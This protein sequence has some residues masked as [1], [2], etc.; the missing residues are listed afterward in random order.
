MSSTHTMNSATAVGTLTGTVLTVADNLQKISD[1]NFISWYD[2]EKT[3]LL[4]IVG[5]FAGFVTSLLLK[6]IWKNGKAWTKALLN[7]FSK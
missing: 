4:A 1:Q 2:I 5:A 7:V 3:V 6:A